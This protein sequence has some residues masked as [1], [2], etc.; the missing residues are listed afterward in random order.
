M[1][2]QLPAILVEPDVLD[3]LEEKVVVVSRRAR[4]HPSGTRVVYIGRPSAL[5]NPYRIAPGYDV[6]RDPD[7]VLGRY[8]RWL[9][10]QLDTDTAARRAI[11]E[12]IAAVCIGETI[13]LECWCAPARCHG[14]VVRSLVL[15]T[16]R[17]AMHDV[18]ALEQ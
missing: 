5:G 3:H 14:D 12:I 6:A 13:A 18:L 15:D 4:P 11:L 9:E 2:R 17:G 10:R 8:A 7:D 16:I 1:T